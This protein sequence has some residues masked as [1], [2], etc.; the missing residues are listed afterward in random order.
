MS[1]GGSDTFRLEAFADAVFAIA[2]TLLVIEIHSPSAEDV[3]EF[4]SLWKALA[5]LW[6]SYLAYLISFVVIGIMWANH[7][8]LMKLIDRVDHGFITLTLLLLLWVAFLPFPT[9]VMAGHLTDPMERA[10]AVAFYCGCFT[11]TAFFYFLMWWHAARGRRLI[12]QHV[13]DDAVQAITR[14]YAPGSLL[15]LTATLMAFVHVAIS[16]TI[17]AGLAILYM[18]PKAGAHAAITKRS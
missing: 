10:A 11:V 12:A 9:A 16:L 8:N 2:I 5:H 17:V 15:Y 6:P 18:L 4:G 7:H 14:A 1:S 3:G 13:P